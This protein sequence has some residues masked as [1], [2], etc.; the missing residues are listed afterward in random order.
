M[1]QSHSTITGRA[2]TISALTSLQPQGIGLF[3]RTPSTNH[4]STE[5]KTIVGSGQCNT[6][7]DLRQALWNI[8]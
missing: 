8:S 4:S 6:I 1:V 7:T 2:V 3:S 5:T